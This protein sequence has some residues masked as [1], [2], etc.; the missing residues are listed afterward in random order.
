MC[1]GDTWVPKTL[2]AVHWLVPLHTRKH[3]IVFMYDPVTDSLV[4]IPNSGR[5]GKPHKTSCITLTRLLAIAFDPSQSHSDSYTCP[6]IL[7]KTYQLQGLTVHLLPNTSHLMINIV[8]VLVSYKA[9]R[10]GKY[11]HTCV[12]LLGFPECSPPFTL[13]YN[14]LFHAH[15]SRMSPAFTVFWYVIIFLLFWRYFLYILLEHSVSFQNIL[16]QLLTGEF[17]PLLGCCA[18]ALERWSG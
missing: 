13:L 3:V 9:Q 7:L 5:S 2:S 18:V 6:F 11:Q 1:I 17:E 15:L 12:R 8:A 10:H 4:I 16:K 14:V